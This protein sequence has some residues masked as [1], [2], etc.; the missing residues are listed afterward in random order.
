MLVEL[1]HYAVLRGVTYQFALEEAREADAL[2]FRESKILVDVEKISKYLDEE[3]QEG[4]TNVK[5]LEV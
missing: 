5:G 1:K 3:I 2:V 4:L